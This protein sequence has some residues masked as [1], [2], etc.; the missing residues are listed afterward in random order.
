MKTY[1]KFLIQTFLKSFFYVFL[2]ILSLVFILNILTEIEFF[3]EIETDPSFPLY[4][5]LLNSPSLIFEMF[6]FIFLISA[7]VFLISL[8]ND[9]Q[10]QI[11]KYSGLKNSIII[12]T[13]SLL[14]FIIGLVI[15]L[16]FYNFSSNFKNVYLELKNK[17]SSDDKYLAVITKNGLWIKDKLDGKINIVNA[18]KINNKYLTGAFITQFDENYEII[19]NIYSDKIDIQERTWI[20]YNAKIFENNQ[21]TELPELK[22]KS[23]FDYRKIQSLFSNLSSLSMLELFNLKKNYETLNYSTTEVDLQIH[24]IISYPFYL[25][26]MTILSSIIMFNTRQ[27]KSSTFK[28]SVGMFASVVIYYV[29]NFFNVMGK[30]EKISLLPSIWIPLI[31]LIIINSFLLIKINEK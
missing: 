29:N 18:S 31:I 10:I 20:A 17:Y 27:F 25:T 9:N 14:S 21:S 12:R 5:S 28:I 23:N 2:I 19:K 3:R 22:L 7:Q 4:L 15:I 16:I 1:I 30:T 11:F 8:F 13:I 6:P 24:K 26:L